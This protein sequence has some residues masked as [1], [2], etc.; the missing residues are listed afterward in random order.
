MIRKAAEMA[1]EIREKMRNGQGRVTIRHLF[2]KD[3]FGAKC[4][5]CARLSL[6]SGASIGEHQHTGEDEL[7]Y[8]LKGSG[9]LIE[10][11][12]RT[13]VTAGDAVLTGKG[14]SH[15]VSND[16]TEDLEMLAM[17]VMY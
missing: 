14:A 13:R 2:N 12:A 11:S 10:G 16:G 4:R 15:Q 17:I 7:F 1:E 5:L 3:E 6:P 8:V 9:V